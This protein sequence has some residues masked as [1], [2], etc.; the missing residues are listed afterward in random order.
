M[1]TVAARLELKELTGRKKKTDSTLSG[2]LREGL[3]AN[4]L[5]AEGCFEVLVRA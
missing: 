4:A 3:M 2:V 5:R 1:A